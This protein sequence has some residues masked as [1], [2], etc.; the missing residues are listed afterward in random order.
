MCRSR[1]AERSSDTGCRDCCGR[2]AAGRE[3]TVT[4]SVEDE[5]ASATTTR[6]VAL[7][8]RLAAAR[9]RRPLRQRLRL[10]LMVA[11]PAVVLLAAGYWFLT[12]GRYV[13]TEDAYVQAARMAISTDVA[14]RVADIAVHDNEQVKAG[15]VLF[16]LDP[17]P[18]RIAVEQAKAQL[19]AER[20]QIDA[21]KATY[22]QKQADAK[23]TEATVAY[24]QREFERRKQLM[25]SGTTSRQQFEQA[26]QAYD[27]GRQQLAAKQQDIANTLAS[28]G[29]D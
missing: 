13:S 1:R 3:P 4:T 27:T 26:G 9:I 8:S 5:T 7:D 2:F 12:S 25:A 19:A 14:G 22:H 24:Q 15:Q 23:A 29:G 11:G 10:P 18:F 6:R 16:R 21:M 28:L 17:R 20:L